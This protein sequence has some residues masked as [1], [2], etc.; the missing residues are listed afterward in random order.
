MFERFSDSAR[1]VIVLAQE[2]ARQLRH[3]YIGTEHILLGLAADDGTAAAV[4]TDMQIDLSVVRAEVERLIGRGE[5]EPTGHV[6]FT[7]RAKKVLELS[8]REAMN[9][10]HNYIGTEHLLLA[11]VREGDGVAA[12]ILTAQGA[13]AARVRKAVHERSGA[14]PPPESA[15]TAEGELRRRVAELERRVTELERRLGEPK[16][17]SG[18]A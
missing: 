1:R 8:L 13:D 2:E 17:T 11:V 9:L 12:Q 5:K 4:L 15:P 7:P 10:R 16:A 18:D 14:P 6:P 3:D